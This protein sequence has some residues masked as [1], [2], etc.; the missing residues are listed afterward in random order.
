MAS[1]I[2]DTKHV[3]EEIFLSLCILCRLHKAT[4]GLKTSWKSQAISVSMEERNSDFTDSLKLGSSIKIISDSEA[5]RWQN[6]WTPVLLKASFLTV[7]TFSTLKIL[8]SYRK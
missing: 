5:Q 4:T 6:G 8:G 2:K 7:T 3:E 1:P